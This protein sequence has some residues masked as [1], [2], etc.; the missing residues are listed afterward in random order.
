MRFSRVTIPQQVFDEIQ[1]SVHVMRTER[2][3]IGHMGKDE[4]GRY[5]RTEMP[6]N[7]WRERQAYARSVLEL[8]ESFER[9]ASY[10]MLDADE[11]ERTIDALTPA[12]AGAVYAGDDQSEIRP[13]LISDDLIQSFVARS[14][15]LGAVNSQSLLVELFRSDVITAEEYSSKI[16]ELVL[17]NYWFVRI[18]ADDILRRLEVNGYRTT[19]GIQAMLRTLWGPDCSEDAA[20]FVGAELI[21]SLAKRPLMPEQLEVLLLSVVAAIRRGRH[22]NQVL[23]MFKSGIAARLTLLPIQC[24]RILQAVDFHMRT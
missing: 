2:A 17:M 15:G 23:A 6:E 21:A 16:E 13:V 14:F 24:A 1:N 7:V 22:T 12:G 8:A 18:G 10:P 19:P 5:T 20:A 11:P 3:P 4:E 9:I